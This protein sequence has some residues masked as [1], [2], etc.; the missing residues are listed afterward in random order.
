MNKRANLN[1]HQVKS[2][3][4]WQDLYDAIA[5]VL[6]TPG[7]I[8]RTCWIAY[9]GGLDSSVLLHA[10]GKMRAGCA[11]NFPKVRAI[12]I[13]H[14]MSPLAAAWADHCKQQSIQLNIPLEVFK[15][16]IN[17]R[18][19]G[20][21]AA[22]RRVRYQVFETIL[23]QGDRLLQGHH[24]ND[25][26]ETV[27]FRVF[28]GHGTAGLAGIPEQRRLGNGQIYRPVLNMS[29][30]RLQQ[31]ATDWGIKWIEDESNVDQSLDRNYIRHA[32]LPVVLNRWPGA[33]QRIEK[34]A[35]WAQEATELAAALADLDLANTKSEDKSLDRA[36][37]LALP[38]VRQKNLLKHWLQQEQQRLS[39]R[40]LEKLLGNILACKERSS[41]VN[42]SQ[43]EA[44]HIS[45][46]TITF[47]GLRRLREHRVKRSVD[48]PYRDIISIGMTPLGFLR[49]V[50]REINPT[51]KVLLRTPR[52]D[53]IVSVRYRE[54]GEIFKPSGRQGRCTLKKWLNEKSVSVW[55]RPV[56]P[57]VYY[58]DRIAA[59]A[60][61]VVDEDFSSMDHG[62]Q[63][64]IDTGK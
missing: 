10:V 15:V 22:A 24:L 4:D 31:I 28:R 57:I 8:N 40:H 21:E 35:Q 23:N 19:E 2:R 27:L 58:N 63:V 61:M 47:L 3:L 42:L 20:I 17:E 45:P 64:S 48:G 6:I 34:T 41:Q 52:E 44:I 32:V 9:S 43:D 60:D 49:L 12:H 37:F 13:N 56:L 46:K 11:G 54:G 38:P 53:E 26:A 39:E 50:F 16:D 59:V 25:Q 7:L 30:S 36:L 51:G 33:L 55:K 14:Q 18:G 1:S 5:R 62:F 29:R